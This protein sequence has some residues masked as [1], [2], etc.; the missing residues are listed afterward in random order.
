M[1]SQNSK[2]IRYEVWLLVAA[3]GIGAV[4]FGLQYLWQPKPDPPQAVDIVFDLDV[5]TARAVHK[6]EAGWCYL[7]S[8]QLGQV[9]G[10]ELPVPPERVVVL[11]AYHSGSPSPD[12]VREM[13]NV[14]E[15]ASHG[16]FE[17]GLECGVSYIDSMRWRRERDYAPRL[18]ETKSN[19][20]AAC[21]LETIRPSEVGSWS[22]TPESEVFFPFEA[23][24]QCGGD[25]RQ[26]VAAI[27]ICGF[28][29]INKIVRLSEPVIVVLDAD[30]PDVSV[31]TGDKPSVSP[32][33]T[34]ELEA[35]AEKV[36][37]FIRAKDVRS[38]STSLCDADAGEATSASAV[39][40][41]MMQG[42]SVP[43]R[44]MDS[45][46]KLL[47]EDWVLTITMTLDPDG[48]V[49]FD[50][51]EDALGEPERSEKGT[52]ERQTRTV[53]GDIYEEHAAVTW[54]HWAWC[55]LAVDNRNGDCCSL[56]INAAQRQ[57]ARH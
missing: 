5:C 23:Y 2:H 3:A 36:L 28:R 21:F 52:V 33:R 38:F 34:R 50:E 11:T 40:R 25:G 44:E 51:I 46:M 37:G 16:S 49:N 41:E 13:L 24:G 32:E 12:A 31:T 43:I 7:V 20:P 47:D 55:S 18:S 19:E 17:G 4:V 26:G 57:I 10:K 30:R 29:G 6:R 56:Q 8:L 27:C 1:T 9:D 48:T 39:F 42:P 45:F 22:L 54:Y 15:W 35:A 53:L 14:A